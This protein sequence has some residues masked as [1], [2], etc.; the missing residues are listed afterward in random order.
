M[1]INTATEIVKDLYDKFPEINFIDERNLGKMVGLI[2]ELGKVNIDD[3]KTYIEKNYDCWYKIK[4]GRLFVKA[5][6]D[7]FYE[8]L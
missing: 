6:E 3:L 1:I 8:S 5:Y 7:D 4:D 2:F